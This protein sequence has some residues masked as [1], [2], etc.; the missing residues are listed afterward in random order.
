VTVR[1]G[2]TVTLVCPATRTFRGLV[3]IVKAPPVE[4][5]LYTVISETPIL[6]YLT[7]SADGQYPYQMP[8]EIGHRFNAE[9]YELKP[10]GQIPR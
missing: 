2:D 5:G 1:E 3:R 4:H 8:Y 10:L 6:D 7:T 9:G